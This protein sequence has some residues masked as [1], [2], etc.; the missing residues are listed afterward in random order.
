[1]DSG[2]NMILAYIVGIIFLFIL[3]RLLLIPAKLL[4]KLLYNALLGALAI[5]A[6]NLVGGLFGFHIALNIISAFIIGLMGLPGFVFIVVL[7]LIFG[8]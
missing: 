5:I 2:T 4:L 6:V 8:I 3:G 1:M 7:K